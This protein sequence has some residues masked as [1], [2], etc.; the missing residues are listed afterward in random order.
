[1]NYIK[2][3]RPKLWVKNLLIFVPLIFAGILTPKP[4][5]TAFLGFVCFSL[6]ASCIYI[7]NDIADYETDRTNPHKLHRPIA[8]GKIS[9]KQAL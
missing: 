9:K 1:M 4:Y 8:G 6:T 7:I 5:L 2:L 3:L